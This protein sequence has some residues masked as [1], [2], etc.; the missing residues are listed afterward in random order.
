MYSLCLRSGARAAFSKKPTFG[1]KGAKESPFLDSCRA[2]LNGQCPE[3]LVPATGEIHQVPRLP[4]GFFP[5]WWSSAVAPAMMELGGSACGP[6][7]QNLLVWRGA[8]EQ[9]LPLPWWS[10]AGRLA[11]RILIPCWCGGAL[12]GSGCPCD[13]AAWRVSLRAA[14][15]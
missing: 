2:G 3:R 11:G 14:S 10:L 9:R 4:R 8:R 5:D 12:A 6:H 13:G 15:S 7:P 1:N